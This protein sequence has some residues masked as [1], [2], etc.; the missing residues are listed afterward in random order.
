[1]ERFKL[2]N[3][4]VRQCTAFF[5]LFSLASLIIFF[6]WS[7]EQ[8]SRH[9]L[10]KYF[11][12]ENEQEKREAAQVVVS[13]I[14]DIGYRPWGDDPECR[15]YTVG[16]IRNGSRPTMALI[17]YPGSGNTWIRGIIERLT[18]YFTGSVYADKNLYIKGI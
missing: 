2:K 15:E 6:Y 4:T 8:P 11:S 5:G 1:M 17:S 9:Q 7:H 13:N 12:Q 14:L 10:L 18:G 3:L 16:F